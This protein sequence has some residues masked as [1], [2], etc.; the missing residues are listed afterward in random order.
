[1][2]GVDEVKNE[3]GDMSFPIELQAATIEGS[4]THIGIIY[5]FLLITNEGIID[6]GSERTP[7]TFSIIVSA[8]SMFSPPF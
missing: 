8:R 7:T 3:Y 6:R 5:F 4:S 1:M 2:L